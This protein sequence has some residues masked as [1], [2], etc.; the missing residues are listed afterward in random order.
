MIYT[1]R[2]KGHTRCDSKTSTKDNLSQLFLILLNSL[3]FLYQA[4]LQTPA[5]LLP[6]E[7]PKGLR[8][9]QSPPTQLHRRGRS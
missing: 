7:Q 3:M 4:C 8:R 1:V 2:V 5:N 6:G 9:N